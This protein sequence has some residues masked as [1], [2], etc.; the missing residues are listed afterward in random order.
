MPSAPRLL[1]K[2][3]NQIGINAAFST[4]VARGEYRSS[5]VWQVRD[6]YLAR[7]LGANLHH[8]YLFFF[9]SI[10]RISLPIRGD[11]S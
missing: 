11:C 5:G 6:P 9:L 7:I 4:D 8:S 2:R 1:V 3:C 10:A